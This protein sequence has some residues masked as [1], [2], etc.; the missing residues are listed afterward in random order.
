M[1]EKVYILVSHADSEIFCVTNDIDVLI[2][3][4]NYLGDIKIEVR[5]IEVK[6]E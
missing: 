6:K 2:E 1:T 5:D 4:L 3:K